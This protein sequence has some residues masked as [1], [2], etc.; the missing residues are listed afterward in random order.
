MTA[1]TRMKTLILPG[2][3]TCTLSMSHPSTMTPTYT[4]AGLAAVRPLCGLRERNRGQAHEVGE[5]QLLTAEARREPGRLEG[6]RRRGGVAEHACERLAKGLAALL[7]GRI[8]QSERTQPKRL[9][10]G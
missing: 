4:P 2:A 9:V 5:R 1:P 10:T 8:H 3:R 7:K 6:G